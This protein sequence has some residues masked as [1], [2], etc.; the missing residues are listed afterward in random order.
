MVNEE[1]FIFLKIVNQ[2]INK[3]LISHEEC[4]GSITNAMKNLA[5][6]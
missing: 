5:F 3:L 2:E 6:G 4:G 1:I